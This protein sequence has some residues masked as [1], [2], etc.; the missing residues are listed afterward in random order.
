[1]ESQV[2][3]NA[4]PPQTTAPAPFEPHP[5]PT[6]PPPPQREK[7]VEKVKYSKFSKLMTLKFSGEEAREDPLWF[8]EGTKSL[9]KSLVVLVPEVWNLPPIS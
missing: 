4:P 5:P 7:P 3:S 9:S 1:M 8:L 2:A 6:P